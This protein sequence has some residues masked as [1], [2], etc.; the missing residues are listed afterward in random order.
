MTSENCVIFSHH[1]CQCQHIVV[2]SYQFERAGGEMWSYVKADLMVL[3][4][5]MITLAGTGALEYDNGNQIKSGINTPADQRS[6]DDL[7]KRWSSYEDSRVTRQNSHPIVYL[8]SPLLRLLS[9]LVKISNVN[10]FIYSDTL[11]DVDP[12]KSCFIIQS[13]GRGRI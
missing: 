4:C 3:L 10:G 6:R 8:L 5:A 13:S 11:L 9:I 12:I 7:G 1:H 2:G